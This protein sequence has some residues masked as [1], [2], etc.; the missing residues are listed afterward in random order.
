MKRMALIVALACLPATSTWAGNYTLTID[1]ENFDIDLDEPKS[2]KLTN[3]ES[4][5]VALSMKDVVRYRYGK[6]SFDHPSRL[7]PAGTNLD[8][9]ISQIMMSSPVGTLVMVQEY[10]TLNPAE[11]VDLMVQE[12][13]KEEANYGYEISSTPHTRKLSSGFEISGKKVLSEHKGTALQREVLA[14][15]MR[16]AGLIIVTQ[17]DQAS[18]SSESD[19]LDRFW[20]TLQVKN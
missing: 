4:I 11:L 13:T 1:G 8:E 17:I 9:E 7:T 6:T 20:K 18:P 5:E 2:L 14:Y 12:L 19:I 3:G 16:D 10:S 15:P